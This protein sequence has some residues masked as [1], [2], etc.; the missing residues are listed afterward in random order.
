M[1]RLI[2]RGIHFLP[3]SHGHGLCTLA[4]RT[5]GRFCADLS[6]ACLKRFGPGGGRVGLGGLLRPRRR[7]GV[8]YAK[9]PALSSSTTLCE[10]GFAGM[11]EFGAWCRWAN[12]GVAWQQARA[13]LGSA[14]RFESTHCQRVRHE[15]GQC[16]VFADWG[17]CKPICLGRGASTGW[18]SH[19][20]SECGPLPVA[21]IAEKSFSGVPHMPALIWGMPCQWMRDCP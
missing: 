21:R 18:I 15:W 17:A 12:Q 5:E 4:L 16:A 2:V 1:R 6:C 9:L 13:V 10:M 14:G 11:G 20:S 8:G 3:K 19:C 7:L